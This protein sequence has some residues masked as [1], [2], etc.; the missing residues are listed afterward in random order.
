MC[1][2]SAHSFRFHI[3]HIEQFISST[4][5]RKS[6]LPNRKVV[7]QPL[8]F[9]VYVEL[10]E[11]HFESALAIGTKRTFFSLT[12]GQQKQILKHHYIQTYEYIYINENQRHLYHILQNEI[13]TVDGRILH[14]LIDSLP[15]YLQGFT[16]TSQLIS[17]ISE[18]STVLN[19]MLHFC[20][21]HR[22]IYTKSTYQSHGVPGYERQPPPLQ[23][24]ISCNT[25]TRGLIQRAS[26]NTGLQ[27]LNPC[28]HTIHGTGIFTY[29]KWLFVMVKYCKCR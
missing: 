23:P 6:Y 18:P 22:Q 13:D 24:G 19:I 26:Q 15:H 14:Q 1:G 3:V 20:N 12:C 29:M 2:H 17:Q 16:Y 7:F 25:E 28:T 9:R 27:Y 11:C 21:Y 10:Q 4:P 8:F 5:P